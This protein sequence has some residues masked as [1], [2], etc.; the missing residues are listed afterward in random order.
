MRP[1]LA[2][3]VIKEFQGSGIEPDVWKLEGFDSAEDYKEINQSN[4]KRRKNKWSI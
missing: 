1:V 2:A 3:E 4:K